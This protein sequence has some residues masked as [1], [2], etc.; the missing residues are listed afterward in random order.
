MQESNLDISEFIYVN[1]GHAI[2]VSHLVQMRTEALIL[3]QF[4]LR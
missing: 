2:T 3:L 1:V 4:E